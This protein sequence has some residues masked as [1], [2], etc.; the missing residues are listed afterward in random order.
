[1]SADVSACWVLGGQQGSRVVWLWDDKVKVAPLPGLLISSGQ[2]AFLQHL[3]QQYS[4]TPYAVHATF[5]LKGANLG[6]IQRFKEAGLWLLEPPEYYTSGHYLTWHNVVEQYVEAVAKAWEEETGAPM[7]HLHKHLVGMAFQRQV[8]PVLCCA[9]LCCAVLCCA[10]LCCAVL[11]CPGQSSVPH[12]T[13]CQS[14]SCTAATTPSLYALSVPWAAAAACCMLPSAPHDL[15]CSAGQP[16]LCCALAS[17]S[18]MPQEAGALCRHCLYNLCATTECLP[19]GV[20]GDCGSSVA[21]AHPQPDS[22]ATALPV[23]V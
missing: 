21:G 19:L 3:H 16:L 11:C 14:A 6:K 5:Q 8:R 2:A 23:L 13:C 7:Q 20:A 9:V 15:S 17:S 12:P 1:M 22:G 4:T 10:V 18:C